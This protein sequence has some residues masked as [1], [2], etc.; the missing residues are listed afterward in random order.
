MIP[1][2]RPKPG[3]PPT[4]DVSAAVAAA[5]SRRL[6]DLGAA[7]QL[8][9]E[10]R[11]AARLAEEQRQARRTA[12]LEQFDAL[13]AENESVI[14][15]LMQAYDAFQA[16]AARAEWH[17]VA[18]RQTRG[19][20]ADTGHDITTLPGLSTFHSMFEENDSALIRAAAVYTETSKRTPTR[21]SV[22]AFWLGSN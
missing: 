22:V 8:A 21:Q 1:A 6:A 20:L 4:F 11:E 17:E 19:E 7:A 5:E 15:R 10:K 18:V 3:P 12:L 16:A 13:A 2:T 14:G 9:H